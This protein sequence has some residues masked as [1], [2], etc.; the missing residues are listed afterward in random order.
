[1]IDGGGNTRGSRGLGESEG[2]VINKNKTLRPGCACPEETLLNFSVKTSVDYV[3]LCGLQR[4][5]RRQ[6]Q[7]QAGPRKLYSPSSGRRRIA[8]HLRLPEQ[9]GED[10][11]SLL[12]RAGSVARWLGFHGTRSYFRYSRA[13][14]WGRTGLG[15]GWGAAGFSP[16]S[17]GDEESSEMEELRAFPWGCWRWDAPQRGS[18]RFLSWRRSR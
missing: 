18:C 15:A 13:P 2:S 8:I 1:M 3:H 16:G 7:A 11:F 9:G 6:T 17:S 5:G 10:A 14:S 4:E 12:E